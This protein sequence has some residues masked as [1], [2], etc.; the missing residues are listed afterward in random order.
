VSARNRI[1]QILASPRLPIGG[2]RGPKDWI[3][4][5]LEAG[6]LT[7]AERAFLTKWMNST[8][9]GLHSFGSKGMVREALGAWRLFKG[10]KR[11][12]IVAYNTKLAGDA[13]RLRDLAKASEEA[14]AVYRELAKRPGQGFYMKIRRPPRAQG[15]YNDLA[16]HYEVGAYLL[17]QEASTLEYR[18]VPPSSKGGAGWAHSQFARA[19]VGSIIQS[20][21]SLRDEDVHPYDEYPEY[22]ITPDDRAFVAALTNLVFGTSWDAADV[23]RACNTKSDNRKRRGV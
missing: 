12:K 22:Q 20:V 1:E 19:M 11:A 18:K 13:E 10:A 21:E 15:S 7:E 2:Y 8:D 14:A 4:E 17:R 5:Q 9:P 6:D 16:T 23:A 3:T